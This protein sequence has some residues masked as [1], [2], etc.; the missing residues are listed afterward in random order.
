[1]H[2]T[3]ILVGYRRTYTLRLYLQIKPN[4]LVLNLQLNTLIE[5]QTASLHINQKN[6]YI[7]FNNYTYTINNIS[8]FKILFS[9][10]P[11]YQFLLFPLFLSILFFL[12][13]YPS[14]FFLSFYQFLFFLPFYQS[15][16]FPSFLSILFF[17][18]FLSIP[19]LS[20]LSINPF[21]FLPFYQFLF[22]PSF[23]SFRSP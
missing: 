12:P 13:F 7:K 1:M 21:S 11:F 5:I 10:L 20:F 3:R 22:F 14:L 23:L 16:F 4:R 18:F 19:F 15:L 9:I 8:C 6:I 2:Y 17:P